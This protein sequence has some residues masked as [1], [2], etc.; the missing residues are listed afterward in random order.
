MYK[1]ND[2]VE[3]IEQNNLPQLKKIYAVQ[4]SLFF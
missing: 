1:F 2:V 3:A 4:P